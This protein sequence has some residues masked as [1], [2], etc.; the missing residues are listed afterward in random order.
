M[1]ME[2]EDIKV[3]YDREE[4]MFSLFRIG[5]KVKFSFDIELPRGDI[6]IDFDFS[7]KIAG[8]EFFNAS[9]YFPFLKEIDIEKIEARMKIQYSSNWAQISYEISSPELKQSISNSI[10]SPY[11][12]ELILES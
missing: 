4:D 8:L 10:I 1:E 11:N 3:N 2:K 9:F 12:K 6:I 7:G 5:S